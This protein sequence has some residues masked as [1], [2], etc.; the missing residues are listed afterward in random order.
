MNKKNIGVG[1]IPYYDLLNVLACFAVIVLHQNY[2]VWNYSDTVSWYI[3]VIIECAFFWAVPVFF[4]L[5]GATLIGYEQRYDTKSFFRRRISRTFLPYILFS[6]LAFVIY[7]KSYS[8]L[9]ISAFIINLCDA[10]FFSIY[11]F[12]IPLFYIY[13]AMPV[14]TKFRL[15]D[16]KNQRYTILFLAFLC[17]LPLIND[18]CGYKFS[19]S[20]NQ[21][22]GPI[23]YVLIGY[24]LSRYNVSKNLSIAIYIIGG[25]SIVLRCILMIVLSRQDG[26]INHVLH[27]YFIPT[28]IFPGAAVFLFCKN[29]KISECV[30][31]WLR[32]LSSLSLGIYLIHMYVIRGEH[33]LFGHIDSNLFYLFPFAVFTFCCSSIVVYI[34][35][36]IPILKYIF[37]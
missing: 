6:L 36:R 11:W 4:M 33:F 29:R 16:I 7:H 18:I 1:K 13:L 22:S 35:K 37:P 2:E 30:S 12:F 19:F 21:L 10:Q 15:A 28:T 14:L 27:N 9:T 20:V 32:V 8:D 34:T 3:H 31:G 23:L 17:T 26:D 25:L 5:S 24:Y